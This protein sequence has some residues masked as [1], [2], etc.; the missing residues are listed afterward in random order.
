MLLL[1][2]ALFVGAMQ[3]ARWSA[4]Q[5]AD[6]AASRL[7]ATVQQ[8]IARNLEL[9]DLTLRATIG[10]LELPAIQ[11]LGTETRSQLLFDRTPRDRYVSFIEA[12]NDKGDV[13][14]ASPPPQYGENWANRDYFIALRS[15]TANELF[16]GRPFATTHDDTAAI[17]IGRRITDQDGKFAG[18][19]VI[20]LRLAYFRDLFNQLALGP[21]SSAALLRDDGVI[22][23]R[24]PFDLNDIGRT[25]DATAPFSTFKKDGSALVAAADS[26]DHVGRRYTFRRVGNLPLVVSIGVADDAGYGIWLTD[27]WL[28]LLSFGTLSTLLVMLLGWLSRERRQRAAAEHESHEKSRFLTTLSHELRTPLH[29]VLGCA[30]QLMQGG[31]LSAAQSRPV[32]EIVR[33]GK[34]MRDVVNVVLDYARIEAFGPA[35][36]MRRCNPRL[37]AEECL[38]VVEPGARAR[39][40]ATQ[41]KVAPGTPMHFVTDDMQFRQ[42]LMN[43]LSNA[44]K[45]TNRGKV[46]L[47]LKGDQEKLTI[48]VIDTGIGIPEGLRHRL[49]KEYERFGAERTSIEGTGLG[50]AIAE[51]LARR[52]G[53]HMGH[54]DNPPGGSIFWLELPA[55]IA[56]EPD[57]VV[58]DTALA[59][60]CCLAVLVVDDSELNR[61]VAVAFL[62]DAGHATTE[63]HDGREAVWLATAHDFDVVLMDM[64]MT[65]LDGLEATRRIRALAGWR[66][67]VPI[68][69]VTANALDEHV[70]QCRRA[71]MSDHLAKP[72]TQAEL[73]A[74]VQ[75]S[76]ARRPRELAELTPTINQQSV[77]ELTACMSADTIHELFDCLASRIEALLRKLA[78]PTPFAAPEL[79]VDLAHELAGGAGALG[80]ST[81]S[82]I[83]SEFQNAVA[84]DTTSA[85]RMV[86]ELRREAEAVLR[87]LRHRRE[88]ENMM[89]P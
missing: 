35:L 41:I 21:H 20:G 60:D 59:P 18:L 39:G 57:A 23:M 54:R 67:K 6:A 74:V 14:A 16:I 68:V 50:L 44:V 52:M 58:E 51:R 86:I 15:G 33:A 17:P 63:A 62:R 24:L 9:L 43:L 10:G 56:T 19:V 72:F 83:A 27:L 53:G 34:H 88:L 22:L 71:G 8:D 49:F 55:G 5:Q 82:D 77:E 79:L 89:T 61:N 42:I 3:Y 45:Y 13:I 48:E 64:R 29:G 38:A 32:A 25:L 85:A 7:A 1:A 81:L 4:Q 66:G 40:I 78:E 70:E 11:A 30:D 12:L 87:E 69:A 73:L 2:S 37:L 84:T 75:R 46:E 65:G 28:L 80:F 76:A 36:H 47:R 26:I 31:G